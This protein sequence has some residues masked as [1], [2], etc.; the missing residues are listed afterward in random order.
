MMQ[1]GGGVDLCWLVDTRSMSLA[2]S[3][4]VNGWSIVR[5]AFE[6]LRLCRVYKEA[7]LDPSEAPAP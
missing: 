3:I 5:K 2:Q 6:R 1:A 4:L 7:M